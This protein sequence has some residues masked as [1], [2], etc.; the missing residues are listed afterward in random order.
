MNN[1]EPI[2]KITNISKSFPGVKALD[3]IN[4][5]VGK[6]EV[7]ALLGENGAGKSTLVK[8]IVGAYKKD[9][10]SII[11]NN[12][13][14]EFNSPAEAYK[15]GISVIYQETSLIPQLT[16]LQNIFLGMEH[17]YSF[18][19]IIDH[20]RLIREYQEVCGKLGFHF[21]RNELA[22]NLSIAEQKMVEILKA[23]VHNASFII[24]DEP[25]DSLADNEIRHLFEIIRD[26]KNHQITVLYITHYLDEVFQITDRITV[27][28]DGK[29]VDT[30]NTTEVNTQDIVKMMVG[31]EI[32]SSARQTTKTKEK[33]EAIR[34]EHLTRK[35]VLSDISFTAYEGEILG[36]T[37]VIGAGKTELGRA[38]FGADKID[39][40]Q[41]FLYG[42][43][44]H[45]YSPV[46]AVK[47]GVGMLPEDRKN[48]GLL[49]NHEVYKNITMSALERFI[50]SM[51]IRKG[52]EPS[53]TEQMVNRLDIKITSP[54]QSAKYLSGGNQQKIV[55]GKWLTAN[56]RILIMDEPTRGIDVGSKNEVHKIMKRLAE[57]GT[58]IIFISSE[59]P[60]IVE[61]SDRI[62]VMKKG[63]IHAEY[64][65]GVTQ[66]EI[67][68]AILEGEK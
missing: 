24:M 53:V 59:V 42:E 20:K 25:T 68:Q 1:N 29:K 31:Q 28:R 43:P 8:I 12:Q 14:R 27:L 2:L 33:R 47:H 21:N 55:V 17:S 10:G 65:R 62:L 67:I 6:G 38:I 36:V 58:C 4:L 16:V 63:R 41:I 61:V 19:K 9:E 26:L 35:N 60:E 15:S 39:S 51:I 56:P 32:S 52:E 34:V 18:L 3:R 11:F 5:N 50:S 23:M 40:G 64:S 37:G 13:N 7:H 22:R 54:Y 57:E 66:K 30:V 46:E 49:L 44:C 48:F 45:I